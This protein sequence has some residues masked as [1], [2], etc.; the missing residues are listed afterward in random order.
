[1]DARAVLMNEEIERGEFNYFKWFPEGNRADQFRPKEQKSAVV[2]TVGEFFK[3]WIER[4]KPPFARPGLHYDYNRQFNRH[5][6]PKFAQTRVI[7]V[8]L[9][10]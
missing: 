7:D 3:E 8:S 6:L 5:I 4:K 9:Q 1:M 10:T 2:I